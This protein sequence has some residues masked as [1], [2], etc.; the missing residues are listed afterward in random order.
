MSDEQDDKKPETDDTSLFPEG[1]N[2]PRHRGA[3]YSQYP[4]AHKPGSFRK[5]VGVATLT[6][7]GGAGLLKLAQAITEP[8]A[9]L[10]ADEHF[11]PDQ[12]LHAPVPAKNMAGEKTYRLHM[13]SASGVQTI[14]NDLPET[15]KNAFETLSKDFGKFYKSLA[16]MDANGTEHRFDLSNAA[17][18]EAGDTLVIPKELAHML[19]DSA[20]ASKPRA[21]ILHQILENSLYPAYS[22]LH[23]MQLY[24]I[25]PETQA[26]LAEATGATNPKESE[27]LAPQMEKSTAQGDTSAH[28]DRAKKSKE[29]AANRGK[30]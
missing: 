6:M 27:D 23:W 5:A 21:A 13:G 22:E 26:A 25:S 3:Y 16:V 7:G 17:Y 2:H 29:D 15:A 9:A 18:H 19:F 20:D 8:P 10:P 12:T 28:F 4:K 24:H 1:L 11:I 30:Y 14:E